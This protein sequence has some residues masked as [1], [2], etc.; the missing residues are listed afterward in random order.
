LAN[1]F[2]TSWW[3]RLITAISGTP[4]PPPPPT[5]APPKVDETAWAKSVEQA[6]VS[7]QTNVHDL[8]LIVFNETQS[9][10][11]RPDSSEPIDLARQTLAHAVINADQK[12]G[13]ARMKWS[14]T[15]GAIEP[16]D[17][18]LRNPT[19]RKAYESSMKAARE[20][21]L[22]GMD[23]TNGA[24]YSNQRETASRANR[25]MSKFKPQGVPLSTQS[26]PYSNLYRGKEV[27]S[28]IVWLNTYKDQ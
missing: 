21:Y 4:L 27:R 20:A 14:G 7:D 6:H 22:S 17:S 3:D 28:R 16:S 12:W 10:T 8:G 11:D 2:D 18:A 5:P 23:P 24:V 26:G 15:A 25:V 19:V 13:A 9:F 1:A